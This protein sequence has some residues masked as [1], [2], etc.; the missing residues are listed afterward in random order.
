MK[1]FLKTCRYVREWYPILW[2]HSRVRNRLIMV[3]YH[4]PMTRGGNRKW[5]NATVYGV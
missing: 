4:L 1:T 3:Q 5:L 2:N